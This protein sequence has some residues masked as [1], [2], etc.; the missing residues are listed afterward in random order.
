MNQT[1][2][3]IRLENFSVLKSKFDQNLFKYGTTFLI[4][5]IVLSSLIFLLGGENIFDTRYTFSWFELNFY[6]FAIL[7]LIIE[8]YVTKD[9]FHNIPSTFIELNSRNIIKRLK[10]QKVVSQNFF[11]FLTSFEE[12]LNY[13]V[14]VIFGSIVEIIILLV[15]QRSGLFPIIFLPENYPA[16]ALLLNFF[17]VFLPM[18]MAGYMICVV[19]W[20]CFVTGYFV[21]R[22]SKIFEIAIQPSHPDKAS[23]LKPLGDLIFSITLILIVASLALSILTVAS[24]INNL[25]YNLL[26]SIYSPQLLVAAP[27]YLMSTEW[28]AKVSLGIVIFLSVIVFF[29]PLITTHRRMRSG[30]IDLLS[31]LTGIGNKIVELEKQ[32]QRV[33]MDYKQRN[34]AFAEITSLSKVN[35]II[36][37]TPVWPFDRGI[38]IKFFTPQVISLLSLFGVVQPIIDAISS[39]LK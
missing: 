21:H 11:E 17:T 18:T 3:R 6:L 38:L 39:W 29:L 1:N 30:K 25:I 34:E 33:N 24:Q 14:P 9:F 7:V 19:F 26:L 37:K 20:K 22:Y 8:V 4:I 12:K 23:G 28:L 10:S 5:Q 15:M 31:S 36:Y 35:E 2:Y 13:P 32:I 27:D 16:T